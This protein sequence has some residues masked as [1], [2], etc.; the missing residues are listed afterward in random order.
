MY[1]SLKCCYKNCYEYKD[2][3]TITKCYSHFRG[4]QS[5]GQ[6]GVDSGDQR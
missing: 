3:C 6:A 2:I 5:S 4:M 1:A